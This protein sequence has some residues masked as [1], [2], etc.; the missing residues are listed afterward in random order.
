MKEFTAAMQ[1]IEALQLL[2]N[3]ID[4]EIEK[5]RQLLLVPVAPHSPSPP[6]VAGAHSI[7]PHPTT[8]HLGA[9][10]GAARR[11]LRY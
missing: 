6:T 3:D 10:L 8:P 5:R 11:T 7:K 9:P 2:L 1:R 4:G